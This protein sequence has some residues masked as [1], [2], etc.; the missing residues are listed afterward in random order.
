MSEDLLFK[1]R[2]CPSCGNSVMLFRNPQTK[3]LECLSCGWKDEKQKE[4]DERGT[5]DPSS[6]C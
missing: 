5:L 3:Q 6:T 2:A 1:Q 4:E